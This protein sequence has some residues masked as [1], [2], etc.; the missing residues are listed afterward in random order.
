MSFGILKP[1]L[2][3]QNDGTE[4]YEKEKKNKQTNKQTNKKTKTKKQQQQ[5]KKTTTQNYVT[6]SQGQNIKRNN[7]KFGYFR[8]TQKMDG[9]EEGLVHQH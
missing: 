6:S 2:S 9:G 7:Q 4:K 8:K 1:K 3:I 5:K